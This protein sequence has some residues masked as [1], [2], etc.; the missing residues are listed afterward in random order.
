MQIELAWI[1]LVALGLVGAAVIGAAV[2]L[3][4]VYRR[5]AARTAQDG[6]PAGP[7]P[8]RGTEATV[9]PPPGAPSHEDALAASSP[10]ATPEGVGS[11]STLPEAPWDDG[12]AMPAAAWSAPDAEPAAS[13]LPEAPWHDE[14]VMPRAPSSAPA[15]E[16]GVPT[17]PEAP[18][19]QATPSS[20]PSST[21]IS[22]DAPGLTGGGASSNGAGRRGQQA[23]QDFASENGATPEGSGKPAH[24]ESDSPAVEGSWGDLST[25]AEADDPISWGWPGR[26]PPDKPERRQAPDEEPPLWRPPT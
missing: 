8:P 25:E 20:P 17:L 18:W 12:A 13:T 5:L 7:A 16:P 24:P 11:A 4:V 14:A 23:V 2:A 21:S 10:S 1:L 19:D 22:S 26:E 9:V 3:I 15:A 6:T